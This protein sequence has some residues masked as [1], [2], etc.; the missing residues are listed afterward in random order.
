MLVALGCGARTGL[1][2]G[3]SAPPTERALQ[4]GPAAACAI[5]DGKLFCWGV[6]QD[7][8]LGDGTTISRS[9]PQ[10]VK[11][12]GRVVAVHVGLSYT[13]ALVEHG[14]VWCWGTLNRDN[15]TFTVDLVPKQIAGT[16]DASS[17]NTGTSDFGCSTVGSA[18]EV[19]CWGEAAG[20]YGLPNAKPEISDSARIVP[21]ARNASRISSGDTFSCQVST[22]GAVLCTGA[23]NYGALGDGTKTHHLT[24][25]GVVGL[26][27]G[28]TDVAAAGVGS[29]CSLVRS[30]VFC[31]GRND[32]GQ[33]GDGTTEDRL[34]PVRVVG[35][36]SVNAIAV[37]RFRGCA[38]RGE[39]VYCWGSNKNGGIGDGTTTARLTPVQV[40]G[41]PPATE[42][43]VGDHF[44]CANTV[45]GIY[46]WGSND[47][48]Q[49]GNGTFGGDQLLPK[50]VEIP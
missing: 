39:A 35:L 31:W 34:T 29:A 19:A 22:E 44:T 43:T 49:L 32:D 13:C 15:G 50:K 47:F 14:S 40:Q 6:N 8:N 12:A 9:R 25:Q 28:A 3:Y 1:G 23:N 5:H 16:Q 7:G 2:V 36:D 4:V 48:G 41:L 20:F 27:P 24:Y 42:V 30:Q 21:S 45:D 18:G 46:C 11:L 37:G 33:L 26:P 17:L 10:E 38:L